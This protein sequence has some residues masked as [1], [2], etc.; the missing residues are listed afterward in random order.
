VITI[1]VDISVHIPKG[2]LSSLYLSEP[3]GT[4]FARTKVTPQSH[5][6]TAPPGTFFPVQWVSVGALAGTEVNLDVAAKLPL[7]NLVSSTTRDQ[8]RDCGS[9]AVGNAGR[10]SDGH[11]IGRCT[12]V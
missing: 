3:F 12:V 1:A 10:R 4:H 6:G 5:F 8:E 7:G 2:A 9:R 11:G